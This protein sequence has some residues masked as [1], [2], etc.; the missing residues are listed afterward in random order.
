MPTVKDAIEVVTDPANVD[1]FSD[2][3]S[4][5]RA[6]NVKRAIKALRDQGAGKGTARTLIS[7]AINELGG[8]V[9]SEVRASGRAAGPDAKSSEPVWYVPVAA[10]R[11]PE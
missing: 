8:R 1:E 3:H 6:V 9:D 11:K 10:I 5:L 2:R 4:D 7:E